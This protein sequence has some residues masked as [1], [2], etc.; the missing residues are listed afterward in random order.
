MRFAKLDEWLAW[1]GT[2]HPKSIDL[3]L[4]RVRKV[5]E[6]LLPEGS[7]NPFTL[8]VGG[9]NGKGS[10]VALLDSILRTEG[11]RVGAYT[12]PIYCGITS[13]SK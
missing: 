12:R 1:Q 8:T 7:A 3:G 6:T 11:Y 5:Y 13:A 4:A 10:S 2:L 9:T